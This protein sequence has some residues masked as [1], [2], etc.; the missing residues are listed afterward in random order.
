MF[1]KDAIT[2]LLAFGMLILMFIG[3]VID[4]I[5]LSQKNDDFDFDELMVI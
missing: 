2:L 3:I 5:K 4:P 1:A